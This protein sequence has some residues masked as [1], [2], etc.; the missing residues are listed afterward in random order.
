MFSALRNIGSKRFM[1]HTH[2]VSNNLSNHSCNKDVKYDMIIAELEIL[3]DINTQ[4]TTLS[5]LTMVSTI[6]SNFLWVYHFV[7]NK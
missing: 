5:Y 4:L 3:K 6:A 2:K 1:T 7:V